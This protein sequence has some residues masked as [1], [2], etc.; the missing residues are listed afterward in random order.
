MSDNEFLKRVSANDR[1]YFDKKVA[2]IYGRVGYGYK[3]RHSLRR[4]IADMGEGDLVVIPFPTKIKGIHKRETFSVYRI[5]ETSAML[6][7]SINLAN[8]L[9]DWDGTKVFMDGQRKLV[10]DGKTIDLGFVRKVEPVEVEIPRYYADIHLTRNM[11]WRGTNLDNSDS[12]DSIDL[13]IKSFRQKG[14]K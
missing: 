6:I 7:S 12:K 5:K 11:G 14:N 2:E 1:P 9:N 4:F 3:N 10:V 13:A 8:D